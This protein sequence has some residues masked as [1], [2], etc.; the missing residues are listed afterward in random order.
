M[1]RREVSWSQ[2]VSEYGRGYTAY[3]KVFNFF[4][5]KFIYFMSIDGSTVCISM[6][7][8]CTSGLRG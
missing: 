1:V 6:H 3:V 8:V 2:A 5:L 4:L 7:H